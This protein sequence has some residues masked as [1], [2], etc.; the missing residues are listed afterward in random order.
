MNR[1][2]ILETPLAGLRLIDRQMRSDRRGFLTRLFCSEELSAAGW[3]KPIA[4]INHTY[5]ARQGAVRGLHYQTPPF[6]EMKLVSCIRGEVWDVAVDLRFGSP[7]FLQWH[8]EILSASNHRAMMIP[9]GFAHGFQVLSDGAELLYCHSAPYN[10][11][12]EAGV[13]PVDV[14]VSI[15]WPQPIAD[16]SDRD[17]DRQHLTPTFA[18]LY[19]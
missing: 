11:A 17:A 15:D 9:E 10:S 14:S 12:A 16:L 2:D 8:A 19:L 5:T 4:Q 7:T 1:F 13:N 18:G 6:A 3:V